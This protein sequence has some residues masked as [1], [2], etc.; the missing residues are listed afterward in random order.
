MQKGYKNKKIF[1]VFFIFS[2]L[3]C[4]FLYSETAIK[5]VEF[6]FGGY[7]SATDIASGVQFNFP[8]RFIKLPENS[9]VIRSAWIDFTALAVG[10]VN[11][12]PLV[13]YFDAGSSATTPRFTSAQYTTQSGESIVVR[14]RADVTSVIAAQL[15]NLSGGVNFTAG[16]RITGPATNMHTA[17]LYITYEYDDESPTQ[18]KT[19][20]FSLYSDWANKIATKLGLQAPGTITMRYLAD[21]PDLVNIYQQWFEISGFRLSSV[22]GYIYIS[23]D[24]INN[25]PTQNHDQSLV[26]TYYFRYLS[27]STVVPGFSTGTLNNLNIY[28]TGENILMLGGEVVITYQFNPNSTYKVKTVREFFGSSSDGTSQSVFSKNLYLNEEDITP[29]ELYMDV[30]GS[31]NTTTTTNQFNVSASVGSYTV[32]LSSYTAYYTGA[33]ISGFRFIHSLSSALA[34]FSNGVVVVSTI[35]ANTTAGGYGSELVITYKYKNDKA[36]T[37]CYLAYAGNSTAVSTSYNYSPVPLYWVEGGSSKVVDSGYVFGD[38]VAANSLTNMQTAIAFNSNSTFTVTHYTI[39]E[40]PTLFQIYQNLSQ[41]NT[42]TNSFTVN[43]RNVSARNTAFSGNS[44]IKYRYTP[45]PKLPYSLVQKRGDTNYEIPISSWINTNSVNFYSFLSSSKTYDNLALS[46][47]LKPY[48]SSFNGTNLSTSSFVSYNANVSTYVVVNVSL[49]DLTEGMYKWRV[50]AVGDGGAGGWVEFNSSTFSFGVDLTSPPAPSMSVITPLNRS[51]FNYTSVNFSFEGVS[52]NLSGVKNYEI[53]VSTNEYFSSISFSSRPLTANAYADLAEGRYFWKTRVYDNAGNIGLWSSTKS[54]IIDITTPSITDNQPGDDVWRSSN[55]GVYSV[56]FNDVGGSLLNK[57][58]LK[59]TSGPNQTGTVLF[60]WTDLATSI[61]LSSYTTPWSLTGSLWNLLSNGTNYISVRVYDNAGNYTSQSDVFYIR[62]DTVPPASVILTAPVSNSSTNITNI[63]FS[64]QGLTDGHSGVKGYELYISTREDFSVVVGSSYVVGLSKAFLLDGGRY[65]WRVRAV[66]NADNFGS[67]SDVWSVLIDTVSPT[68][69]DN[70]PGDDVWRSSNSGVYSVFF[71]DVGGSLLSKFQLKATSGPNQT[72]TVLFDWTD[73]ATSI[74]L[75][76]YTTPWSLTGSLWDLLSSGTNYISVR[77]YDNAGNYTSQSDVF[78]I[79]KDTVPPA[80]VILTAP[81]SNSSTNITNITF[82]WQGLTDGHSGVKG[83][84]LYISTREDFSV[85]VGSSYVVGLSKAFLLD[86]GRYYWR[87]R[88]VDNADN[89]GSWSDVWSVLIDTVSPTIVDN[90][91]GDDVERSSNVAT[92]NV[93]FYDYGGSLLNK[94]QIRATTDVGGGGVI[95]FD[96][97]DVI[98][99]INLSSYPG[100]WM[101]TNTQFD[102]LK[103]GTNYISIRVFDNAG[104]V[105]VSTD[106]FYIVKSQNLPR[107]IDNQSGDDVWRKENNG[108]YDVD[109]QTPYGNL[110]Y[111]EIKSSTPNA[112]WTR[113]VDNIN[114]PSYTTDWQLPLDFWNM[115]GEGQ[116]YISIRVWNSDNYFSIQDNVFYVLKDTT[117]PTGLAT[118]P[119]YS[120]SYTFNL[121]YSTSDNISGVD[122]V[123]LY[124][125]YDT[126]SP[127]NWLKFGSTFTASPIVFSSTQ[128]GYVGFKIVAFD[129]AANIEESTPTSTTPPEHSVGVD[130][131]NPLI[132]KNFSGD[133]IWRN[134]SGTSYDVDFYASGISPLLKAQYKAVDGYGNTLIDWT[135]IAEINSSS[136]LANWQ[137]NF[138]ALS[139]S[140]NYISVR[141]WNLAG[142]TTTAT[143]L[144]YIKKDTQTPSVDDQQL[145]DD[146]WRSINSGSYS[147]FFNDVGG[148]LLNKFQVKATSGPNQSRRSFI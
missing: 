119:D 53:L 18:I 105:W 100:G 129:K 110:T 134:A 8:T 58:Q 54:F 28:I 131:T 96:W 21:L 34:G 7:Y 68:I 31:N 66:D 115:L 99:N 57:F 113:V 97:S 40:S 17:K 19:V 10:A 26:D 77:V 136:Y 90:Q 126:T 25:E 130:L 69:V 56:F 142:T 62:K 45:P 118:S 88:A 38:F 6:N 67:W 103:P 122:Y 127:Y 117:H 4:S 116:S 141:V 147:V 33:L 144:F 94:F 44:V 70:Q 5:T 74:N 12:N 35:S 146:I 42:S 32:S 61:N 121:F 140:Y 83:Y 24:G 84:E 30:V 82:S 48:S 78:Y 125:T 51:S 16:V 139:S 13:I 109:F 98:T 15:S 3:F 85:V 95:A 112:V 27:S 91:P 41:I 47:E 73:L 89:F 137:V 92:Y 128:T 111:F 79:R 65:Y 20:R 133:D 71:N 86:G 29:I 148:S 143:N 135:D 50:R 55:S 36:H 75:S 102:L 101:I 14:A 22:E 9:K 46:L 107:I 43:Y 145:G 124:Y 123:E 11:V 63:T 93:S 81:V 104:N 108:I 49:S 120:N 2:Q 23:A 52:D 87:V 132:V 37:T 1:I 80:S 59:A 106:V 138:D 76:S 72:G 60:D 39:N 114:L 64:W